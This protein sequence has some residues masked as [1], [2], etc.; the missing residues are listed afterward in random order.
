[1]LSFIDKLFCPLLYSK[2]KIESEV[3]IIDISI[4]SVVYSIILTIGISTRKYLDITSLMSFVLFFTE[5][6]YFLN[7]HWRLELLSEIINFPTAFFLLI[8]YSLNDVTKIT[9]LVA[10]SCQWRM[11]ICFLKVEF[12]FF[13]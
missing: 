10:K 12:Y 1:M 9:A 6:R 5:I 8:Y 3:S 7:F 4:S 11:I 2:L 13:I